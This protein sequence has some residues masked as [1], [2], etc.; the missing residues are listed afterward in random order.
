VTSGRWRPALLLGA[1]VAGLLA[2]RA[3]APFVAPAP[4]ARV[5][6]A[7]AATAGAATLA[8]TRP[9]RPAGDPARPRLLRAGLGPPPADLA[10][11]ADR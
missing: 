6:P 2:M 9:A 4:A 3:A 7:T 10:G 1:L 11:G 5:G 8:A